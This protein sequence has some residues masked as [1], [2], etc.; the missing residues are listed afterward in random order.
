M[1]QAGR[2]P[3]LAAEAF[4]LLGGEPGVLPHALDGDAALQAVVPGEDDLAHA[5]PADRP[6]HPVDADVLGH[7]PRLRPRGALGRAA[8]LTDYIV[9]IADARARAS[10]K[11]QP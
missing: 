3:G 7:A 8:F 6:F 1:A 5:T 11:G 9:S 4:P 2:Q 10:K